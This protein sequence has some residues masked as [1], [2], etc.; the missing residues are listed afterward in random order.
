MPVS[1]KNTPKPAMDVD[2]ML[3][4]AGDFHR[5]QVLL[6]VLFSFINIL[7]A[8]DFFAQL[9]I[10]IAPQAYFCKLPDMNWET[11]SDETLNL[12]PADGKCFHYNVT[13]TT[14]LVD[15]D[16][17]RVDNLTL[18]ACQSGWHYNLTSGYQ[19]IISEVI[20]STN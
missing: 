18:E 13:Q 14:E 7:S 20:K 11:L 5:Y 2:S 12:G 9:F 15:T 17:P 16:Q 10:F 19:S 1:S 4:H 8:F 6:M 3:E